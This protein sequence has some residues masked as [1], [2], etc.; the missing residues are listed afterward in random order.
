MKLD[1]LTTECSILKE[2]DLSF[3]DLIRRLDD[4]RSRWTVPLAALV[5]QQMG[6]GH[7]CLPLGE[8]PV[9]RDEK[10][11]PL[12]LEWPDPEALAKD[13][14][15]SPVVGRPGQKRPLILDGERLYLERYWCYEKQV[16]EKILS[17]AGHPPPGNHDGAAGNLEQ[18]FGKNA[19]DHQLAAAR[20][21]INNPFCVI[22]GGPGTGKTTTVLKI[23]A[24]LAGR[25]GTKE[26]KILLT[27]PTGK[28]AVRLQETLRQGIGKLTLPEKIRN[29]IPLE[30]STLHRLLGPIH[31]SVDFKH[32]RDNPL[33]A[34]VVVVDEASMVD[35]PLMAKLLA[36]IPDGGRL[37][38]LGDQD[39][40]AS[41]DAGSVL[42]DIC[43]A[44]ERQ[45]KA[46][47]GLLA[48]SITTL[49]KNYRFNSNSSLPSLCQFIKEGKGGEI[50]KLLRKKDDPSISCAEL[51]SPANLRRQLAEEVLEHLVP[52]LTC[53]DPMTALASFARYRILCATH[54]GPYGVETLNQ[55]IEDL[56]IEKQIIPQQ[57]P[58]Y[59][60]LPIMVTSNDYRLRLY[61]GD[62]GVFFKTEGQDTRAFFAG[63]D[64]A[65]RSFT[66][67]RLPPHKKA[68]S[69]TIHKSQGSEFEQI[70][71]ILPPEDMP[72]LTRELLY[73]AVSRARSRVKVWCCKNIFETAA[74]RRTRRS[75]GLADKL[76]VTE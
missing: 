75:S 38:L 25:A 73:T 50:L 32:N 36:A 31:G 30:A 57:T 66:P 5:S 21:A 13:I 10:D 2:I 68:Y 29:Q 43:S 44:A 22:A 58:L 8:A 11:Q 53:P 4:N 41:V 64:G 37:I 47:K 46:G 34:D 24:T 67:L 48:A 55:L 52:P 74:V 26:L 20:M 7:I 42:G 39:Q 17:F 6:E 9:L 14:I 62:T 61:N 18:Y 27:A 40:L 56:L 23:L 54:H 12:E 60:G 72:L 35:L 65:L 70:L 59:H 1:N 63:S 3:A 45:R 16:A 19:D 76:A 15:Q 33:S 69:M 71:L 49:S 51:P 28:A